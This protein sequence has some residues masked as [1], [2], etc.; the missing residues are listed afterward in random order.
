MRLL[1]NRRHLASNAS[2]SNRAQLRLRKAVLSVLE[3]LESRQ[4]F[5]APTISDPGF[6]SPSVGSGS[7]AYAYTPTGTSWTFA[8]GSGVS[9][10]NS[11]FTSGNPSAPEGGQVLFVQSTSSVSQSL[12]FTDSTSYT[13][14]FAAAQRG[15]YQATQQNFELLIDSTVVGTFDPGSTNYANYSTLPFSVSAGTHTLTIQALDTA[16][17]DNTVFID[18]LNIAE[19]TTPVG[20]VDG[21]FE[22]PSIG[23]GSSAYV[24]DPTESPWTFTSSAGVSGN[25][26]GFTA[27]NPAAPDGTQVL[28][29]A[30]TGS[31]SQTL[32]GVSAGLYYLTFDAA[33]RQNYQSSAQNIEILVDGTSVDSLTPSGTSYNGYNSGAITLSGTGTHTITLEGID[34]AGGDNTAFV[35]A[36]ALHAL[37]P[38]STPTNVTATGIPSEVDVAWTDDSPL[39]TYNVYRSSDGGATQTLIASGVSG[40]SYADTSVDNGTEYQYSISGTNPAGSSAL[41]AI[42]SATPGG[43]W[44]DTGLSS[45]PDITDGNVID[46]GHGISISAG[47]YRVN[48]L[49]G[50]LTY[51]NLT[52]PPYVYV[53]PI[54]YAEQNGDGVKMGIGQVFAHT[55]GTIGVALGDA[56]NEYD[57]NLAA[58][59]N[60]PT[61]ELFKLVVAPA[62]FCPGT[63][64]PDG[65]GQDSPPAAPTP[66]GDTPNDQGTQITIATGGA[67][68]D[69]IPDSSTTNAATPTLTLS[70]DGTN[71]SISYGANDVLSFGESSAG[72]F[73]EYFG[74]NDSLTHDA[75]NA[76]YVLTDPSGNVTYFNDFS[77]T[78]A[79]EGI[80][81]EYAGAVDPGG[82]QTTVT[83]YD[84]SGHPT[85]IQSTNSSSAIVSDYLYSYISS[86]VNTGLLSSV[87][88]REPATGGG[89]Q[90]VRVSNYSYYDGTQTNGNAGDLMGVSI[91]DGSG[92]VTDSGYYRFY[93]PGDPNG[94]MHLLKYSF[95][96]DSIARLQAAY[97][98]DSLDSLTDTQV[99]PYADTYLAYDST[100][101]ITTRAI[102]GEGCSS[103]SGGIGTY[104]YAYDQ[105][106]NTVGYNSWAT[107]QTVT[108]P[109]GNQIV[110]YSNAY[111]QTML[112][113]YVDTTTGQMWG[114]FYAYDSHGRQILEAQP[115]A[116][117]LPSSLATI[118]ANADLLGRT[119]TSAAGYPEYTYLSSDSGL[120]NLTDYP[121]STTATSIHAGKRDRLHVG[122]ED[123]RGRR[124]HAHSSGI[125]DL[126]CDH[127]RKLNRL[128]DG[129]RHHVFQLR[130]NRRPHD[131]LQLHLFLRHGPDGVGNDHAPHDRFIP[132]WAR[133]RR[134]QHGCL[135]CLR[136]DDLEQGRRWIHLLQ[137]LRSDD[138]RADR[139]HP[140]REHVQHQ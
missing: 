135:R 133:C 14:S 72:A 29:L 118:E 13:L 125:V 63:V 44:V 124:R 87:T 74:G 26:S 106:D 17:G 79:S 112:S 66:A 15:N 85:E 121:T 4:Y 3:P 45:V 84:S 90:T 128:P 64:A 113:V 75:T 58:M 9:G 11:A 34:S 69:G 102:Q 114:T 99:A 111:G 82:D 28:F 7:S 127:R 132:E 33:Q 116:V 83:S 27:G 23:S 67:G 22:S 56:P 98:G 31:A 16:G 30:A 50:L 131:R 41:S 108:Q 43:T 1:S 81:G 48:Y 80:A 78:P 97:P 104:T 21:S 137:R 120:I 37:L 109:D 130:R 6:E 123:R 86:G 47:T 88:E 54:E 107:K 89:W 139:K 12:T 35:D 96:T 39:T 68:D 52:P 20:I 49:S 25:G 2:V 105:S 53:I 71:A 115:S 110:T 18:N 91:T 32:S 61:Y 59:Y 24:Y 62:P 138:R 77:I 103:C 46:F 10:N 42:Q 122:R 95:S 134:Q 101:Q 70:G 73:M 51:S 36:L 100:G 117:Q 119:G 76:R 129:E 92:N 136:P 38:P 8:S 40:N 57:D 60:S 94:A 19:A 140:G 55:A 93:L 126:P 65:G 5:S